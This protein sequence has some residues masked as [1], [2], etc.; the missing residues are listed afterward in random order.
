M[1]LP[2]PPPAGQARLAFDHA[3][4]A[5]GTR[6][7][8][9]TN[10]PDGV[11]DGPTVLLCNGLGTNPYAW[12]AF[13]DPECEVRVVSWNHRGTGGSDRP[14]DRRRVGVA[15]FVEDAVAVMDHYAVERSV[16]VGW[17][18]GVNTSFQ[19]A[20]D[21]P[22]RVTGLFAVAGVPGGTFATMLSPLRVPRLLAHAST[23]GLARVLK[24]GGRGLSPMMRH[25]PVGPRGIAAL[26]R[27]GFMFPVPDQELAA[28]AV[29]EFLST[30]VHWYSHLALRAAQHPRVS[31]SRITVPACFVAASH[32]V[33]AGTRDMYTA[34]QRLADAT[35]V[36]LRGSHFI[37]IEQP[38]QVHRLLLD[39]LER[40]G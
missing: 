29:S 22:E 24:Y 17:S 8:V 32:D 16:V 36:E 11:L 12:P 2:V 23:V 3:W 34:A 40:V 27:T 18:V 26:G 7:R 38:E 10:D 35:Y 31:L 5:D 6:L 25:L 21:H 15:E 33:M 19:L 28:T 30:P 1:A 39:F 14:R 20:V 4:S 9:W 37:Q 13:L